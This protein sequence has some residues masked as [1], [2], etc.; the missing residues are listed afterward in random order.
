MTR[1]RREQEIRALIDDW[2][3][4][5]CKGD[6]RRID[7]HS[8]KPDYHRH[9]RRAGTDPVDRDRGLRGACFA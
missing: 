8:C 5:I 3:D 1:Q 2:T 4:A 7:L 6:I 9:L